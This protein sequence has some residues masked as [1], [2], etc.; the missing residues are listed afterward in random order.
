M[1]S[2]MNKFI[3]T[4][5]LTKDPVIRTYMNNGQEAKMATFSVACNKFF[6][7][8]EE[9]VK[10]VAFFN[11]I[12]YGYVAKNI[13]K[14]LH[15]GDAVLIDGELQ[16]N[17]YTTKTG[18][19]RSSFEVNVK[20]LQSFSSVKKTTSFV[21]NLSSNDAGEAPVVDGEEQPAVEDAPE[22]VPFD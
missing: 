16:Q 22:D 8:G 18:E 9:M 11:C 4:A 5:R 17:D 15:K 1:A 6:K 2:D 3:F 19:K 12:A 13:E 7:K 20:A 14:D 21:D 10:K